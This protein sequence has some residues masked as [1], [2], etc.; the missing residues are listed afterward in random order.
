MHD[1]LTV[2]QNLYF[3]AML[4]LPKDMPHAQKIGII[5][6]VIAILDLQNIRDSVVGGGSSSAKRGISG[7]Q[8]KRVNIGLEL[9]SY[10]RIL[11]LDEPTSG[12]DS[13][14]A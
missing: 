10:P 4:R 2:Y 3:S 6:D 7:G 11:F 8:K 1:D 9:V 13:T 5:E 12:L 14:A